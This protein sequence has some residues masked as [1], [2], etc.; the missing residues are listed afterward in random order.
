MCFHGLE[1]IV[2]IDYIPVEELLSAGNGSIYVL[3]I[4]AAKRAMALADGDEALVKKPGEKALNTA[5]REIAEGR[6]KAK[7]EK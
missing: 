6:I 3:T 7:K 5:L 1:G 4:L 2:K